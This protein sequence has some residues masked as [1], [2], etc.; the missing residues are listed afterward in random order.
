MV[1]FS[2]ITVQ[3]L[4]VLEVGSLIWTQFPPRI[5]LFQNAEREHILIGRIQYVGTDIYQ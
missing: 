4:H 1:L 5:L 3:M 2:Q